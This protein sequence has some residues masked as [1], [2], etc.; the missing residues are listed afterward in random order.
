MSLKLTPTGGRY[1]APP[2]RYDHSTIRATLERRGDSAVIRIQD[3][4]HPDRWEH[5]RVPVRA[6]LADLLREESDEVGDESAP[7]Q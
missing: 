3:I 4:Q 6:L 2:A 5:F 1:P 7:S